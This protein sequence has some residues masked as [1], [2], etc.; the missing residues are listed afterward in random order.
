VAAVALRTAAAF[1]VAIRCSSL[2][3]CT[4][5]ASLSRA[6]GPLPR[7]RTPF[8]ATLPA[9]RSCCACAPS[10]ASLRPHGARLRLCLRFTHI[11]AFATATPRRA[12]PRLR[13]LSAASPLRI[14]A[15]TPPAVAGSRGP[16][17]P[18]A[19]L[20]RN[21]G[22]SNN[23]RNSNGNSKN[24]HPP[25]RSIVSLP[26]QGRSAW[27]RHAESNSAPLTGERLPNNSGAGWQKQQQKQQQ[28]T[29]VSTFLWTPTRTPAKTEEP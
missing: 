27:L 23:N 25:A 21:K 6:A 9:S 16:Q 17:A 1:G 13:R 2:R 18:R 20:P 10:Y 11:A 15:A 14:R 3:S 19:L 28:K 29:E 24:G 12:A 26:S 8:A 5:V 22:N 7:G 4:P